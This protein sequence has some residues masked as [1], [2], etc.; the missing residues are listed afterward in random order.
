MIYFH[1]IWIVL[2][3]VSLCGYADVID[4]NGRKQICAWLSDENGIT[5]NFV[6]HD[7]LLNCA[8]M[9]L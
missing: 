5:E 1:I 6:N 3:C 7:Y 4:F 2:V 9:R 8:A